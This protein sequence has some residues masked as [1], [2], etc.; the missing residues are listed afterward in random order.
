M[1]YYVPYKLS[2]NENLS[3]A[4]LKKPLRT[5]CFFE[6]YYYNVFGE[7]LFASRL[8]REKSPED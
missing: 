1:V 4:K 2:V 6:L 7:A 8:W 3:N 5:I